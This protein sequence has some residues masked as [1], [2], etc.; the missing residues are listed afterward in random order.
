MT[1]DPAASVTVTVEYATSDGTAAAGEDYTAT[2]GTLTFQAGEVTKTI[3]VP[4]TDDAED[5]GGETFTLTLSNASGAEIEDATGGAQI[6]KASATGS[7]W[8]DDEP[9][10]TALTATFENVPAEHDGET[11]FSFNVAFTTNVAIGYASMR[12]NAFTVTE[13]DV[14]GARRVDRRSDRWQITV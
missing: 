12:D 14:T 13:G 10:N 9:S 11:S 7:I 1:L 5:D 2:S 4:I 6:E 8:D 3:S